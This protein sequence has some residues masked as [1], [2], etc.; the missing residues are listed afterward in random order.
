M[1]IPGIGA[2]ENG[3][4]LCAECLGDRVSGD[5]CD[6]R[7]RIGND[8]TILNIKALDLIESSTSSSGVGKELSNNREDFVGIDGHSRS[9][10][11]L[12]AETVRIEITS[13]RIARTAIS[14]CG[15][16]STACVANTLDLPRSIAR[17]GSKS[18]RDGICLPDIHLGAARS[19][20]AKASIDIV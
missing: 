10:E 8:N 5:A 9:V 6:L 2:V 1:L 13:I 20:V 11:G 12:V 17:M 4:C 3:F 18:G 16:G 7:V 19:V 14:A 15:V